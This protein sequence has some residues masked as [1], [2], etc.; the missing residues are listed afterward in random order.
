M[1][2]SLYICGFGL[3]FLYVLLA[4]N[5]DKAGQLNAILALVDAMTL[6]KGDA[7]V[8]EY[9]AYALAYICDDNGVWI[10]NGRY[11][12]FVSFFNTSFFCI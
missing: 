1:I 3:I 10:M 5:K 11:W 12:F 9:A 8:A 2:M 7:R 4:E 6:H